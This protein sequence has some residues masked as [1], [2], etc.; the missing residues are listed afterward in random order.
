MMQAQIKVPTLAE[1]DGV[2]HSFFTRRGGVSS[3]LYSSLNC[4]YGSGDSPDN[5]RENRRRVAATFAL[6][7]PDLLT[8]HQIHST[9]VLTVADERWTSPGAPKADA[10]VTDRPGVVLGVLAADCAPVL[11]ADP[12]AQVIGAAHAGWKGALNGVV[13]TTIAA[14]ERLGARRDRLR[15]V[16]GPCIGRDSYEVG[17]EF[18]APFLAQDEANR[19][20][21]RPASR[22]GHFMFD[23]AGYLTHRIARTGAAVTATGH[24]TL[25]GDEDFFSY[26]R[27]TLNGVRDYGRGLSAIALEA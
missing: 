9:D 2:Q 3:G 5:V 12:Q 1:L 18:P 24:D 13:D 17:P 11:L 14:M 15:I 26:R 25:A 21:F 7:E 27:N 22:T 23:L 8:V 6:G 20:F 10:L 19:A 16:I 4:G